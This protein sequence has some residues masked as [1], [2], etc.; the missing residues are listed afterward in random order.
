M[1]REISSIKSNELPVLDIPRSRR[2]Q[3]YRFGG[4]ALSTTC[5]KRAAGPASLSTIKPS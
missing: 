5:Q 3:L 4:D 2:H 1:I